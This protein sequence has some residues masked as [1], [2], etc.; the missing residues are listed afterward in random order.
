MPFS[1]L[2]RLC[3]KLS[4]DASKLHWLIGNLIAFGACLLI[5]VVGQALFSGGGLSRTQYLAGS[6]LSSDFPFA[7]YFNLFV[8]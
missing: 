1:Q 5:F 8:Q 4:S 2:S 6:F 7:H 3:P